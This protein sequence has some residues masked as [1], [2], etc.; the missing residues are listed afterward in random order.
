MADHG[1]GSGAETSASE[2]PEAAG[3]SQDAPAPG[4]AEDGEEPLELGLEDT[5]LVDVSHSRLRVLKALQGTRRT[6]SELARELDLNKSTVHG[7]LQDLVEDGLVERHDPEDRMWVYYSLSPDG[8][9]IVDRDRLRLVVD[10]S[11][12]V[13]FLASAGL[14]LHRFLFAKPEFGGSGTLGGPSGAASGL[15]WATIAYGGLLVLVVVGL[16]LRTYLRRS[17]VAADA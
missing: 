8:E 11:T 13:A 1:A 12:A 5:C 10:L 7:Y 16:A 6:G 15:P 17:D 3:S 4:R 14:G 9:A 2:E